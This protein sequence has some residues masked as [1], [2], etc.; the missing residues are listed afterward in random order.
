M[1][2]DEWIANHP[3]QV[4][5]IYDTLARR[6]LMKSWN[7]LHPLAHEFQRKIIMDTAHDIIAAIVGN[8]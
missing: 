1:T 2:A 6:I 7:D 4:S 8:E 3:E 5:L